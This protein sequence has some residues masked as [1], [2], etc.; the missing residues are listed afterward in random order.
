MNKKIRPFV[1]RV[2]IVIGI[3]LLIGLAIGFRLKYISIDNGKTYAETAAAK[4]TKTLTL[5]GSRG[6]IYDTNMV[7]LAY[8]R[9]SYN[10]TF[11]RDPSRS[12]AEARAAYTLAIKSA[13]E[14]IESMGKQTI[15]E[16][17]LV[18]D[19]SGD[20]VFDTGSGNDAVEAKRRSQWTGN[21]YLKNT[22]E[23]EKTYYDALLEKYFIDPE[24]GEDM[25][26]KILAVWQAS[27]MN[28]YTSRPVVIAEDVGFECVSRIEAYSF[29]LDGID[30]ESSSQRVYP[31][32][33]TACHVIGYISKINSDSAL[34]TYRS[35]GYPTNATVGVAGMEYS[36]ED[37]L[38][39]FIEYRSG[40]RTVEIDT[41]G[42]IV[43]ELSY[44]EPEDGN[45]VVLTIDVD[46]QNVMARALEA[47]IKAIRIEQQELVQTERWLRNNKDVL[48]KYFEE[49]REIAFAATGAMVAMDPHSGRVLGMVSYP[50][51]DLTMFE[52]GISESEWAVIANDENNPLY[53]RAISAKDTPGSIF[54]L[55]T[56]LAALC[57]G[58]LGL[59]ERISD[60]GAFTL[61]DSS[62]PSKCW[63]SDIS[64]HQN[65]T[66]VEGLKNSCNYF[67]YTVGYRLGV[68][69]INKW[70]A[71]LGL[72]SKTNIELPSEATSFVGSQAT[73]YDPS[74]GINN[75]YTS[76][77]LFIAAAIKRTLYAVGEDRGIEYDEDDINSA[78]K[79]LL[80]I[81][82][83]YSQKTEWY[84][85]IREILMYDLNIPSD[86][87]TSH[88]MVNTFVT[89]IQDL[90]WTPNET[91][92]LAIGQSITQVTPVAVARYVSAIANGGTVYDAQIIDKIV[93]ADG[94]VVIEKEPVIA[95]I[96]DTDQAYFTAIRTG[97]E[98][99][100]SVENDGTAADQFATA[101]Y[102]IA[103]KTGTS[104]RTELD[105]ENNSWL[106]T[107]APVDNPQIVV[108]VYIQ[109][110]Y[111]GA[112]ASKAAI[113]VI[114]YYLDNLGGYDSTA[115]E[116][117][118]T[119]SE[120]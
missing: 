107:Y 115:V 6:A 100:T 81:A 110:G 70:A 28:A 56:S 40:E 44:S 101:K 89:Y 120:L 34:D 63:T 20:W 13:I 57:E 103:A 50:D 52:D 54:K 93:A 19:A 5:Y 9:T 78:T 35:K 76:K 71:A 1:S 26:V 33:S 38:T 53:N 88:Y 49:D 46:L 87:I 106:V 119:L 60:M 16:F 111:A 47:R 80:D 116:Q 59:T 21:F 22:D 18:K 65:Q 68:D 43:R 37:Q 62:H 25:T 104:E 96:I 82:T 36:M 3:L 7:P 108:V 14:L 32:G 12:S 98:E 92:M 94:T 83:Q 24:W 90:Y 72:T 117:E 39:P 66:I 73:L 86:Y 15:D 97:M 55:C 27:R 79:A 118:F 17:W 95:N 48:E 77:P 91:I 69:K 85:P 31:L 113:A 105:V 30:V 23:A 41:R 109:N 61:T 64:K 74:R 8:D 10:I 29:N 11:Y 102:R 67:F 114:E 42:K 75:Q 84:T 99:V 112:R 51:F 58:A 45:S 4:S 2:F